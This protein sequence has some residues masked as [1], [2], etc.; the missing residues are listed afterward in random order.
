MLSF[1]FQQAVLNWFDQYGRKDL[2][3]QKNI[4]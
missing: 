2:P 3:W 1:E 4:N